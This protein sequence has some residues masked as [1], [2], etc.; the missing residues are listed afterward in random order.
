[1][2][3]AVTGALRTGADPVR[4]AGTD[5]QRCLG[6]DEA[7]VGQG[8]PEPDHAVR[9]QSRLDDEQREQRDQNEQRQ[10][11][12]SVGQ[13]PDDAELRTDLLVEPGG[14]H[15]EDHDRQKDRSNPH[16]R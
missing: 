1:M 11:L 3:R 7:F 9:E 8:T 10:V 5:A 2:V 13:M 12:E 15:Q 16:D 6:A 14:A 4:N